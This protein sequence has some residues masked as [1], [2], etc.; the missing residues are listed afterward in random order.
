AGEAQGFWREELDVD[1]R[2]IPRSVIENGLRYNMITLKRVAV[3]PTRSGILSIEPLRIQTEAYVPND[4]G[5][6]FERFFSMRSQYEP[7]DLA[8]P[9]VTIDVQPLPGG[10][11]AGF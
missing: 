10:A 8:S 9:A 1:S 3:F 4:R 5:N 7:V 11:P 2:P 6:P